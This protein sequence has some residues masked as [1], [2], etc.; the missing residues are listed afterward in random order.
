MYRGDAWM[1]VYEHREGLR[2]GEMSEP[3]ML[4]EMS[5]AGRLRGGGGS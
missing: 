3:D 4:V 1:P 2:A 5:A